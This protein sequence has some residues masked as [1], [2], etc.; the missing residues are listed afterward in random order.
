MKVKEKTVKRTEY[1]L[2]LTAEELAVLYTLLDQATDDLSES[3]NNAFMCHDMADAGFNR[4]SYGEV[5]ME[6][7]VDLN[8]A[9]ADALGDLISR[10]GGY[11]GER[12]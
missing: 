7:Y 10:N 5:A 6:L 8:D 12:S 2:K 9:A 4:E 11:E 3:W 1:R